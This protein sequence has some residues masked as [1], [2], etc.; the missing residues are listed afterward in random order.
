[1]SRFPIIIAILALMLGVAVLTLGRDIL[2]KARAKE[3]V[4]HM[5]RVVSLL[6]LERPAVVDVQYLRNMLAKHGV[7]PLYLLDGWNRPLVVEV[8]TDED[9]V[10]IYRVISLGRNGRLDTCCRRF[11][12]QDWDEDAVIEN[13]TWLQV[14]SA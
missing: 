7:S 13:D 10:Q 9:G 3:T 8:L 2:N 6:Q 12:K 11:L 1:M 5:R 4:T 14:W